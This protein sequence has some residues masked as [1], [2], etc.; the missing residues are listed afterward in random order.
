M[1]LVLRLGVDG[2]LVVCC[3]NAHG[4]VIGFRVVPFAAPPLFMVQACME[5]GGLITTLQDFMGD[6]VRWA[7]LPPSPHTITHTQRTTLRMFPL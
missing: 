3:T 4:R 6:S 2:L 1:T 7:L 5:E